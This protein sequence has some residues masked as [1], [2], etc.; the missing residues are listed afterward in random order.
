MI[1]SKFHTQNNKIFEKNVRLGTIIVIIQCF[2]AANMIVF[3]KNLLLKYDPAVTTLIYYSIGTFFTII[4]C[5]IY[6]SHFVMNDFIFY[7]HNLSWIAVGYAS[8]FATLFAY[9]ATSWSNK[10]LKPSVTTVYNT[11]Q[12]F[13]TVLLSFLFLSTI[14][15]GAELIGGFVIALGLVVTVHDRCDDDDQERRLDSEEAYQDYMPVFT[16]AILSPEESSGNSLITTDIEYSQLKEENNTPTLTE[17]DEENERWDEIGGEE[18][19]QNRWKKPTTPTA[20][21]VDTPG[22]GKCLSPW[23]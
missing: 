15:S 21:P 10:R 22:G 17:K 2:F 13:G 5:A 7:G 18:G 3:Q 8:I 12:P 19:I 20:T 23:P 14:P 4:I 11:L 1:L 16:T 9:N 6:S